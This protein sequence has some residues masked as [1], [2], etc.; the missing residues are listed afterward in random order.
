[1]DPVGRPGTSPSPVDTRESDPPSL[2]VTAVVDDGPPPV[3]GALGSPSAPR[4]DNQ[5]GYRVLRS[6]RRLA[7]FIH[8]LLT[9]TP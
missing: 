5:E 3:G 6:V 7:R 4:R 1:M 2:G 9:E 8:D